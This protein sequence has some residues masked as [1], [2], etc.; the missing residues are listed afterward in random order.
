MK[1]IIFLGILL[2]NIPLLKAQ[3]VTD[4]VRY[5]SEKLDGTARFTA[6]SGAFGALGGDISALKINPAGSSVFLTNF[7]SVS[8][9]ERAYKNET[10]FTDGFNSYRNNNFDLNQAGVVFV[11]N[12]GNKEAPL[13]RF[14]FGVAYDKT[15]DFDNRFTAVGHNDKSVSQRFL[16]FAQGVP[17]DL[18]TPQNGENLDDLY[19][20]LGSANFSDEG[21]N[22]NS[23]QTAYLGYESYLFD[24]VDSNDLDN[25]AYTSNVSG[26]TFNEAYHNYSEGLNGRLTVNGGLAIHNKFFFGLNLNSH[27]I[28]YR[29]TTILKENIPSPSK[30]RTINFQ[31]T[32]DT[33]GT[34]FSFQVG[35]IA[36]LTD[37]VRLGVSY[38][39]PTW[40]TISE[41]TTQY[42]RTNGDEYG[43]V[44]ANPSITNVYPDYDLR[45]PGKID[46]SL[47]LVFG[48][49]GLIS[50]DYSYK[51]F[52][53]TKYTS[54]GFG[55]PNDNI[56]D[57][58][59]GAST[60]RVGGEY[61]I[62]KIS[63]RAGFRYEESPYKD[64]D[65]IGDL[66]GYSAGLGYNFGNLRVDFA[67]DL[68]KRDYSNQLLHTGFNNRASIENSLSHYVLTFAFGL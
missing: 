33:K 19:S 53:N 3:N 34:G 21:F 50:F 60:Y 66:R 55:V 17:L 68:S 59:Q 6:M 12:N 49:H 54:R 36:K 65:V 43:D 41:E 61:R 48:K 15:N 9:D 27:Y 58:L 24:A 7:A 39:S 57:V 8:L 30:I 32:L 11:F 56:A 10:N 47:G 44:V 2:C 23:L 13:S 40:Y 51:D 4:A 18:F 42:L 37:M 29:R 14:S 16:N 62:K 25:T 38:Q 20:Y 67:Y 45:T 31:N 64:A 26:N 35:G 46:G 1:K 5:A 63:L 28:D 52:S 22:N